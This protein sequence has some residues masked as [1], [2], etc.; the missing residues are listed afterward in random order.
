MKTHEKRVRWWLNH[1]AV[2]PEGDGPETP[3]EEGS[4]AAR[5]PK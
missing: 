5:G 4:G 1:G 3:A 2:G